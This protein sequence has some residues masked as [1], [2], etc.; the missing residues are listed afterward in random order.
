[1]I[2]VRT[3]DPYDGQHFKFTAMHKRKTKDVLESGAKV[4]PQ[5]RRAGRPVVLE[6]AESLRDTM[7]R[8]SLQAFA[9]RG[10]DHVNLREIAIESGASVAMPVHHFGSKLG[11]W[12]AV[13]DHLRDTEL[14][15]WLSDVRDVLSLEL[16]GEARLQS[17]LQRLSMRMA[18]RPELG[19]LIGLEANRPGE[20]LDYLIDQCLRPYVSAA[21]PIMY[22]ASDAG[23]MRAI[24]PEV[25]L[26]IFL[27][28][29]SMCFATRHIFEVLLNDR[30]SGKVLDA[31]LADQLVRIF[32]Q[33]LPTGSAR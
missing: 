11:L 23:L 18:M 3:I 10:F 33:P 31:L 6:G 28:A 20:P 30:P 15:L 29:M 26:L 9:K 5:K 19:M 25:A 12:R 27:S 32:V 13:V 7:I 2:V 22:E 24:D 8:V 21:T 14:R 4:S 1:M 16:S 17:F